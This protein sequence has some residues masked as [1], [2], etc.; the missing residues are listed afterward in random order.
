MQRLTQRLNIRLPDPLAERGKELSRK[1]GIKFTDL[2]R[3]A[4]E[5]YLDDEERRAWLSRME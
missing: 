4:L 5:R 1:K 2:V 3:A